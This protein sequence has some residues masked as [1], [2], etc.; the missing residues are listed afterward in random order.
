[1]PSTGT[2]TGLNAAGFPAKGFAAGR[3]W[4]NAL[5]RSPTQQMP[6]A[7]SVRIELIRRPQSPQAASEVE[8]EPELDEPGVQYL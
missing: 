7:S 2:I 4:A 5:A 3:S 1:M 8:L 6:T